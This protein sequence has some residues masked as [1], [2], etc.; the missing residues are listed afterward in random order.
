MEHDCV[1]NV[2]ITIT[3]SFK[4]LSRFVEKV[5]WFEL[6]LRKTGAFLRTH[7]SHFP[8]MGC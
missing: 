7:T 2:I 3:Q 6:N 1:S 8:D 4:L 5:I